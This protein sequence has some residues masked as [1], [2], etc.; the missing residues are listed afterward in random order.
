MNKRIF[1]EITSKLRTKVIILSSVSLFIG[2]TK[3]IPHDFT[4][5]GLK[6]SETDKTLGWFIFV[7]IVVMFLYFLM[8]S[9]L[10][11]QAYNAQEIIKN[12]TRDTTSEYSGI[13]KEEYYSQS[14]DY[15]EQKISPNFEMDSIDS[16]ND[17]ITKKFIRTHIKL[18]KWII[19]IF[20]FV[21]PTILAMLGIYYLFSFLI[22]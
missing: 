2:V 15:A 6:L 1:S 4:I 17:R 13:T 21:L 10:E 3:K 9:F 14:D 19:Y 8:R 7:A 16:Q 5:I 22:V 18:K 12:K 11:I 20:E